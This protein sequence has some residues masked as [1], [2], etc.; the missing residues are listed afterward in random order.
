M[1]RS[2]FEGGLVKKMT[3]IGA[4]LVVVTLQLLT[5][6]CTTPFRSLTPEMIRTDLEG[7]RERYFVPSLG[8]A[9]V[10]ADG[11]MSF[12]PV[13]KLGGSADAPVTADSL[14]QL[15]SCTKAMTATA[16]V[17]LMQD[18]SLSW[19]TRLLEI[20]PEFSATANPAYREVTLGDIASH[21]AGFPPGVDY[22]TWE[23]LRD[24]PGSMTQY[25]GELLQ[26]PSR[27]RRGR[28]LY[29]NNG[30][31]ALGAVIERRTGL[32]YA[33]A[34]KKLVFAP[35]GVKAHFGFPKELGPDQ[36]W[37]NTAKWG[38]AAPVQAKYEF[39]PEVL[40]PAGIV[41]MTLA[42][43]ARFLQLHLRGLLGQADAGYSADMIQQLHQPRVKTGRPFEQVYTAGWTIERVNG[44]TI[45]WHNGSAGTFMVYMAIN[46]ARS[47][48]VVVVTNV[49]GVQG[50]RVS[51]DIVERMLTG[52]YP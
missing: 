43:Y 48:G 30:Y 4:L 45:H 41:S 5:S 14:Y 15:G 20:F 9:E 38:A 17:K 47:K 35:L 37:G 13:G 21:Q 22:R 36:P 34:M 40:G 25:L 29:S 19:D 42:D 50:F 49:G 10:T 31:A 2:L 6:G 18:A 24:Y 11:I 44:E 7:V 23:R 8:V 39:L 1:W 3:R 32:V 51:W 16:L 27:I 28:Y 12:G 26:E 46:P 33:E 52:G